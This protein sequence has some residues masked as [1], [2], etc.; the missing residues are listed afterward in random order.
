MRLPYYTG[1]FPRC[2]WKIRPLITQYISNFGGKK[3][4]N[5]KTCYVN[6][7]SK[8]FVSSSSAIKKTDKM[9]VKKANKLC[10]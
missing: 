4:N 7:I 10:Y 1:S 9:S 6:L 2:S 3:W 5:E 8:H